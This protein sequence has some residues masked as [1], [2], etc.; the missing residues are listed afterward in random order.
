MNQQQSF[1][2]ARTLTAILVIMVGMFF[3]QKHLSNKYP[4]MGK[5]PEQ[6]AA[7]EGTAT[8]QNTEPTKEQTQDVKKVDAAKALPP[9]GDVPEQKIALENDDWKVEVSS[10]GMA[11]HK[12]LLKKFMTRESEP[13]Q[14]LP[15]NDFFLESR[16][17]DTGKAFTFELT[18]K[19]ENTVV[20]KTTI[21]SGVVEKTYQFHP[22]THSF[23]VSIQVKSGTAL[24]QWK[25]FSTF[26][27]R[28]HPAA[29]M[30]APSNDHQGLFALHGGKETRE[31]LSLDKPVAAQTFDNLRLASWDDL[32]F[33]IAVLDQSQFIP[34]LQ[35]EQKADGTKS[36]GQTTL[37]Y[38]VVDN[39]KDASFQ[40]K[41]YTG[42][43]SYALLQ[44]VD[45]QLPKVIDFGF[46]G[47]IG[48]YMLKTMKWFYSYFGNYGLSIIALTILVRFLVLPFA[49]YSS[50][51]MKAMQRV[52]P[53]IQ[54]L[55]EKYKD[56]AQALNQEMMKLFKENKVNPMGGCL[57]MLLQIPF[58][59]ALYRVLGVSIELYQAPFM[60]WIHDLSLKDPFY[61]LPI[62]MGITMFIQQ[63]MTPSNL[64]PV[65]A[66]V[67]T[68]MP[69]LFT[70]FMLALPSGLTLY[71]F[72]STLF[73]IVQ[74]KIFMREPSALHGLQAKS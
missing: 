63:K 52:Q 14:L 33:A 47:L 73:G 26:A 61:V 22:E 8:S 6:V 56:N 53:Q 29:S 27:I 71:L 37:T 10:K 21:G 4:Q 15:E 74:Q 68:F 2:D 19:D 44:Q 30:F 65:Q 24:K 43:K 69:I 32:Y 5:K 59:F 70:V 57:P 48:M 64:D 39:Q 11:I 20:G 12:I 42:P 28:P 49:I 67:L 50:R 3:W 66:K 13:V 45:P 46:F 31:I 18:K 58:F 17:E 34:Q 38:P 55:K 60:F 36:Y 16:H 25:E 41:A 7:V 51:S 40:L 1:F 35:A 54:A 9:Q 62:L 23:D 72:V